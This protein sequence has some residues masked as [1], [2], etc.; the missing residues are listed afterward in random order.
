M[1]EIA[2]AM[3]NGELCQYCGVYL[4]PEEIVYTEKHIKAKMPSNGEGMGVP[5]I[6]KDCN[7]E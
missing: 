3:I 2:E 6:C 5:V 7:E 1:G 4:E